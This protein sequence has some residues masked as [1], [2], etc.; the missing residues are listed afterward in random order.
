[1]QLQK[2]I[3][4]SKWHIYLVLLT[5]LLCLYAVQ[6]LS[7]AAHD[8]VNRTVNKG[9]SASDTSGARPPIG[10]GRGRGRELGACFRLCTDNVVCYIIKLVLCR[11]FL[12]FQK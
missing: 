4:P 2:E 3:H 5:Y 11:F 8:G 1:M 12:L 9:A 6:V 10:R 7:G